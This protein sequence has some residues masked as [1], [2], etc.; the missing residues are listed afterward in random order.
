MKNVLKKIGQ[1]LWSKVVLATII[2][3]LCSALGY[4]IS[5]SGADRLACL[6]PAV[7]GCET[8]AGAK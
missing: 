5:A 1:A 7:S 4:E 8:I 6:F 2:V 3:A